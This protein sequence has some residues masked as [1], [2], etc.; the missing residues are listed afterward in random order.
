MRMAHMFM[1]MVMYMRVVGKSGHGI[2]RYADG[3]VYEGSCENGRQPIHGTCRYPCGKYYDD[4]WKNNKKHGK[5]ALIDKLMVL[6]MRVSL[7]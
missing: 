1:L 7:S 4:G 5:M 3:D 6:C 2:Y